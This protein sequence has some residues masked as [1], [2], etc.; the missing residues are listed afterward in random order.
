MKRKV[1]IALLLAGTLHAAPAPAHAAVPPADFVGL[2]DW[3]TPTPTTLQQF[4]GAGLKT[5]RLPLWW[6]AVEPTKGRY[7]WAGYDNFVLDAARSGVRVFFVITGCPKWACADPYAPPATPDGRSALATLAATAASR[8]GQQ[9]TLWATHRTPFVPVTHWQVWN[10]V[11]EERNL[12][13][14]DPAEY[15]QILRT[16][17][18]AIKDHDPTAQI[19]LS[20]LVEKGT[21]KWLNEFLPALYA[22][23][24]NVKGDFDVMAI[25]GYSADPEGFFSILDQTRRI[26]A[27]HGDGD[28]RLWVTEIGWGTEGPQHPFSPGTE[29]QAAFLRQAFDTALGCRERWKLDRV[30]WFSLH[31]GD[32]AQ[33]GLPDYWGFHNGLR[34]ADGK[35]KPAMTNFLDYL[36]SKDLVGRGDSCTLPGGDTIPDAPDD[37]FSAK[38]SFY[39]NKAPV[40][41]QFDPEPGFRYICYFDTNAP[42]ECTNGYTTPSTLNEGIYKLVVKVLDTAGNIVSSNTF[43]FLLDLSPPRT[44]LLSPAEGTS[45][46]TNTSI[47]Y[48]WQ[49]VDAGGVGESYECKLDE[50]PWEPCMPPY[51]TP[52]GLPD[53]RHTLYI[54]ATDYAGNTEVTVNTQVFYIDTTGPETKIREPA[55]FTG[56]ITFNDLSFTFVAYA[57]VATF[58]CRLDAAA[59]LACTSPVAYQDLPDG[60]H[61]FEVRALDTLGNPDA[62]PDTRAFTIDTSGPAVAPLATARRM[63]LARARRKKYLRVLARVVQPHSTITLRV[64]PWKARRTKV[65]AKGTF[66]DVPL[67]KRELRPR[68]TKLGRAYLKRPKTRRFKFML[69]SRGQDGRVAKRSFSGR[70][71]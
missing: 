12:P 48:T 39:Y 41:I 42:A 26:M 1:L 62:T 27:A 51:T 21:P 55:P 25:H 47:T 17:R 29:L 20:G 43:G 16:V 66:K 18:L 22:L 24:P 49:A 59:W 45:R 50:G 9:G 56:P 54:R 53:G 57:K 14:G 13:S 38:P 31:N 44:E 46:T 71:R 23:D 37:V 4:G 5:W 30:F 70:L 65:I 58:E 60:P 69:A 11:N 19:V 8:Y 36:G 35:D 34:Y 10:E 63:T 2:N 68:L 64:I 32:P 61:A 33:Q 3:T 52:L 6:A 67:G 40:T 15:L 28:K 7:N